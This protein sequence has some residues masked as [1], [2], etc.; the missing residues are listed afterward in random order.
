MDAGFA[1]G[2]DHELGA[3]GESFFGQLGGGGLADLLRDELR[4]PSGSRVTPGALHRTALQA[5]EEGFATEMDP[6][7]LPTEE[8]LIDG[9]KVGHVQAFGW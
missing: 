1:A 5:D 8:R 2:Q 9:V 4:M 3:G 7:P 6:L